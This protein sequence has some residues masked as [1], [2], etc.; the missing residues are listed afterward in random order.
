[1]S[2]SSFAAE[3]E[4]RLALGCRE[5]GVVATYLRDVAGRVRLGDAY[6]LFEASLKRESW[7]HASLHRQDRCGAVSCRGHLVLPLACRAVGVCH[8]N[9]CVYYTKTMKSPQYK[10]FQ[11]WLKIFQG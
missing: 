2:E 1:M 11:I 5:A 10:I 9:L 8:L 4:T 7:N 3:V 6:L